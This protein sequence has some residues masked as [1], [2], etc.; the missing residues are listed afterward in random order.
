MTEFM[1]TV[2]RASKGVIGGSSFIKQTICVEQSCHS[3]VSK[4]RQCRVLSEN[5]TQIQV[6]VC[7]FKFFAKSFTFI[8]GWKDSTKKTLVTHNKQFQHLIEDYLT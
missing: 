6:Q 7:P 8:L 3:A 1:S 4:L 5:L 2:A